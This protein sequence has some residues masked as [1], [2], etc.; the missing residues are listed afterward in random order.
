M[1]GCVIHEYG[2]DSIQRCTNES[3]NDTKYPTV[4]QHVEKLLGWLERLISCPN[5]ASNANTNNCH[6]RNQNSKYDKLHG[7]AA[8]AREDGF[9]STTRLLVQP[10]ARAVI[11]SAQLISN[12]CLARGIVWGGGGKA[13]RI[14]HASIV[15]LLSAD[16]QSS[17]KVMCLYGLRIH[18]AANSFG[19]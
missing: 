10:D 4:F 8:I 19:G 7:A 3:K 1:F 16:C 9:S 11:H 13:K 18:N 14:R 2:G 17:T 5:T 6:A 12:R 15:T